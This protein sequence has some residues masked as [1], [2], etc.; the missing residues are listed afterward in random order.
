[1]LTIF[2]QMLRSK[3]AAVFIGLL[4]LGLAAFGITDIFTPNLGNSLVQVADRS[5]NAS[6]IDREVD[7][8]LDRI[9]QQSGVSYTRQDMADAGQYSS[10]IGMAINRELI[11]AYLDKLGLTPSIDA[12]RDQI[13]D[14][15]AFKSSVDGRFSLDLYQGYLSSIRQSEDDYVQALQDDLSLISMSEGIGAAL[16]A[17]SSMTDLWSIYQSEARRVAYIVITPENLTEPVVAPTEEEV[18][19][20]YNERQ[21]QLLEPARRGFSI[22]ALRPDDFLHRVE[23]SDEEIEN[24]YQAQVSR[25]SAPSQRTFETLAFTSDAAARNA[26]GPLLAGETIENVATN[27]NFQQLLNQTVL[28]TDL[29]QA[30]LASAV[31]DSPEGVWG[32]PV[33]M[34]DGRVFLVRTIEIIPGDVQPLEEVQDVVRSELRNLKAERAYLDAFEEVD[35]AVGAGLSLEEISE[36]IGSPIY[37]LPPVDQRGMTAD[38][39]QV[40]LLLQIDGALSYGFELYPDETSFRQDANDTQFIIRLDSTVDSYI[41]EFADV[42]EELEAGLLQ[43][44]RNQA[45]AEL[46]SDIS[47]RISEG[48]FLNAEAEA[49][50]LEVA[51]PPQALRR[52]SGSQAGFNRDALMRIFASE[53][54]EPFTA[55]LQNG[56][57]LGVVESIELPDQETLAAMRPVVQSTLSPMIISD[58]EQGILA[59]A[60]EEIP[61]QIN[62]AAIQDY[63]QQNQSPQ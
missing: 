16:E 30:D 63:I 56:I 2:R 21:G 6:D 35:D 10:I 53:L 42:R 38:G 39:T 51:R 26:L 12:V 28:R 31:F 40:G 44:K 1:M 41:P 11:A 18:Q 25:W 58:L 9:N 19:T 5:I 48:G 57:F 32:G 7:A 3:L 14:I 46:A 15:S 20:F 50:G 60:V 29:Q 13:R 34:P 8:R 36:L 61:P 55:P 37:T 45:L 23:V 33:E 27:N 59:Q 4:I 62:D 54:D 22:V 43:Q 49:L 47:T 52:D 24:E 17:P